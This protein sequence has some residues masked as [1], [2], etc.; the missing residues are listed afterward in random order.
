MR[1]LNITICA[2]FLCFYCC[3]SLFGKIL[4]IDDIKHFDA[5]V[6]ELDA[7]SLVLFDVDY[8]LIVPKDVILGPRGKEISYQLIAEILEN[9]AVVPTDK[10]PEDFFIW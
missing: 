2:F 3:C 9:P 7:Q 10:Y 6:G 8:T 5:E 4:Q 1:K